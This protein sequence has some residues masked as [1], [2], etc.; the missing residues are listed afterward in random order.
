M[1][2]E[3]DYM[4]DKIRVELVKEGVE[5]NSRYNIML[6]FSE[7]KEQKLMYSWGPLE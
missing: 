6:S 4:K 1:N 2:I 5:I 7:R 3:S